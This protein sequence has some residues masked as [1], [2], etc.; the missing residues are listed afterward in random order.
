MGTAAR[1]GG[2]NLNPEKSD[3]AVS[4]GWSHAGDGKHIERKHSDEELAAIR[5]GAKA[6]ARLG[7]SACDVYLNERAS[8]RN[9]SARVWDFYIGRY[10]IIKK[11]FR[12]ASVNFSSPTWDRKRHGMCPRWFSA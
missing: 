10:Q 12:I 6:R 4:A 2:G 3:L 5:E 11:W 9:V 8:R 1:I 7:E